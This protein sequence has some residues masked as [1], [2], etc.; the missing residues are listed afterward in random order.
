[1]V[2]FDQRDKVP[3]SLYD[4]SVQA[5]RQTLRQNAH[6]SSSSAM[7][8]RRRPITDQFSQSRAQTIH[9]IKLL[10]L[11]ANHHDYTT[12]RHEILINHASY[13]Y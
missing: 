13:P 10:A 11:A 1:M 2:P 4:I 5:V 6:I 12:P 9:H 3:L 8:N 7:T